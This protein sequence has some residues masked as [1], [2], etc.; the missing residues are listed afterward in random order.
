MGRLLDELDEE[1]RGLIQAALDNQTVGYT[2]IQ[3]ELRGAG[4]PISKDSVKWHRM[5][6]CYC[7]NPVGND[8]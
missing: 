4:I 5:G 8:A 1:T 6:V 3:A 2:R 7:P